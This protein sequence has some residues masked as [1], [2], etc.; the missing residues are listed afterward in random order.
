M[1]MDSKTLKAHSFFKNLDLSDKEMTVLVD[2]CE[3]MEV[4]ANHVIFR[5]NDPCDAMYLATTCQINISAQVTDKL[6]KVIF[7]V[8]PD[9]VFGE[10]AML[11]EGTRSAT[12]TATEDTH[13]IKLPQAT[14]EAIIAQQPALGSKLL[15]SLN[16]VIVERLRM[17]NNVYKQHILWGIEVSGA[18]TLGFSELVAGN[19]SVTFS[20]ASGTSITGRIVK[21]DDT[22]HGTEFTVRTDKHETFIIPYGSVGHIA[23]TNDTQFFD[24]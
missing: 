24:N 21:V 19:L 16:R 9:G 11:D 5:E 15:A 17:L 3:L 14:L 22:P 8:P 7:V 6:E 1:P 18:T 12:A 10:M 23:I 13:L 20:L 2:A 4:Q